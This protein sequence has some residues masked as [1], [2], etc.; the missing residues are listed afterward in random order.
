MADFFGKSGQLDALQVEALEVLELADFFGEAGQLVEPQVEGLEVLEIAN[1]V[2]IVDM[3]LITVYCDY[4]IV[5]VF[6]FI[7]VEFTVRSWVL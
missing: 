4:R 3:S 5:I 1:T 7:K 6:Y 2:D